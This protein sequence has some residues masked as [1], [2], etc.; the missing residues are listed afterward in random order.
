MINI[1]FGNFGFLWLFLWYIF[2][3]KINGYKLD[4]F[5]KIINF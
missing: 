1:K 2:Y 3:I 5:L 4:Y